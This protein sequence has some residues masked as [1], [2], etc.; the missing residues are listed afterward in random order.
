MYIID[1]TTQRSRTLEVPASVGLSFQHYSC[2]A[3]N[4]FLSKLS[5][6]DTFFPFSLVSCCQLTDKYPR[7]TMIL[8]SKQPKAIS[9]STLI[10]FLM[11]LFKMIHT[12][13]FF[14]V[15]I[16]IIMVIIT[17]ILQLLYNYSSNKLLALCRVAV[18]T[19][20]TRLKLVLD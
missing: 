17:I 18:M 19:K 7:S 8:A 4:F 3:Q 11:Q 6:I 14:C 1:K 16:I 20:K 15:L 12:I 10:H 5:P 2:L 9:H 13:H